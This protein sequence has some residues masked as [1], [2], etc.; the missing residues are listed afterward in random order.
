MSNQSF[1]KSK[2]GFSWISLTF[3]PEIFLKL[4]FPSQRS[5]ELP[6]FGNGPLCVRVACTVA[7]LN[8]GNNLSI[9]V[10]GYWVTFPKYH[11]LI[12]RLHKSHVMLGA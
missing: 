3:N 10:L 2:S 11:A 4:C 5:L 8:A 12:V 1:Y 6:C 7:F 9:K